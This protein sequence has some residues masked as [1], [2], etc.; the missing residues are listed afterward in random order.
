MLTGTMLGRNYINGQWK[1][2]DGG[3]SFTSVNPADR[4]DVIGEF[5][6]SSPAE[7]ERAVA[8][9]Q[10]AYPR[11]R[12][13]SRIARGE[14]FDRFAL[15]VRERLEEL[16]DLLAREAGKPLDEA[17]AD[18]V[19]GIHMA[20]YVFGSARMTHGDVISSEIAEK[21]LFMRRR[22]KGVVAVITPWNFPFAVPLWLLAPSLVEGNTAV[23]K[24]S[25]ETPLVGQRM[26]ELFEEAGFP[27]GVVNL[28]QGVGEEVGEALVGH[29]DVKVVLFTGSYDV[30]S[31]IKQACA[32]A[33][34]KMA[35]CEM[36][37]KSAVI[38]CEDARFDLAINAC[39]LSGFKTA[40]QRCVSAGRLLVH[41]SLVDRFCEEFTA[42]ARALRIGD[43]RDPETF[44]G[45]LINE[46]GVRKVLG[47]NRLAR[48]E[49]A[50]VLL[51]GGLMDGDLSK[52]NFLSPFVYRIE[53]APEIRCIREEVFGP[54]V[55]II[56]FDDLDQAIEV[57]NDTDYG[58]SCAVITENYRNMRE[59]RERCEFGLGY[60]NAPCI[61]AE[62]HLPF[63]G[64]K[65]SGVGL[66]SASALI[67]SV[68][69]RY[70]WTVNHGLE[71]KMA[72]G[73][74]ARVRR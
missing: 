52:G 66:P 6:R 35:V 70:A 43:P 37:S 59:V 61:G 39:V 38:V 40:G 7:V 71:I 17:R 73:M 22:P 23:F 26:I 72:Q 58:L 42:A 74:D 24:P 57:Y 48:E 51:D 15:L 12:A 4:D 8:A 36:G 45:P 19:E 54:H 25:E 32:A 29:P 53:H 47:Y 49:G 44:M 56:P 3:A 55:A 27:P 1:G 13:T 60:V 62:V 69:H 11:W 31:Q 28:V 50:D 33:P 16:T 64:V 63:G 21:D 67:D 46:A 68:T 10:S 41:R 18:I 2:V 20:Q 14:C 65:K 34:D 30:G 9:A 5:P